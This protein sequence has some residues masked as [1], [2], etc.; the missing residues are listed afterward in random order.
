VN[1]VLICA[2][3][4]LLLLAGAY[5]LGGRHMRRRLQTTDGRARYGWRA[6]RDGGYRPALSVDEPQTAPIGTAGTA[7]R[8][9]PTLLATIV[10]PPRVATTEMEAI[11]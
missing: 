10:I 7:T 6:P 4:Q 8:T 1:H 2:G 3:V 9:V 5:R 11:R